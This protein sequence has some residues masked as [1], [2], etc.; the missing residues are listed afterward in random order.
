M[1]VL[2]KTVAIILDRRLGKAIVFHDVI[3]SFW[4]GLRTGAASLE[5]KLLQQLAAM[6]EDFLY[7]ICLELNK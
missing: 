5:A 3:H 2:W 6:R 4:Y 7:A 1:E